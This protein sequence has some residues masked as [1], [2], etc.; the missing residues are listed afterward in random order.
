M[1]AGGEAEFDGKAS[2]FRTCSRKVQMNVQRATGPRGRA[3]MCAGLL[4]AAWGMPLVALADDHAPLTAEDQQAISKR[5]LGRMLMEGRPNK[6]A[7]C[8]V[9]NP[10]PEQMAAI[11][12]QYQALPPTVARDRF[13]ISGTSWTGNGGQGT[14]GRS[15]AAQLTYSFPPDGTT[16]GDPNGTTGP[17]NLNAL[18]D[19]VFGAGNRDQGRELLRQ[20][21]A[22]WRK[23]TGLSY[24]EVADDGSTMDFNVSRLGTR[25]DVRIGAINDATLASQGVLAYNFFPDGGSDMTIITQQFSGSLA[26]NANSYRY[27]RNTVAHEHG[28]GLGYQHVVPCSNTKLMEPFLSTAFDQTQIDDRRGGMYNY[29]DRF[30]GNVDAANARDFGNLTST[31][32]RS[33]IERNLSTNRR[34]GNTNT[35]NDWFRFTI[36][37]V[38][39]VVITAAPTGGTYTQ[40]TQS[41][42]CAGTTT[43][44]NTTAAGN[45][46]IELRNNSGAT[47]LQT[48]AASGAGLNEVL[49]ANGL[50]AGTYWVRVFDANATGTDQNSV[51]QMYDLTIRVGTSTAAPYAVAGVNKRIQANANCFFMGNINSEATETGATITAYA[52]DLDGNGTFEN[53]FAQ[54]TTTY[55]SNGLYNV[56]LR[57]TDSNGNTDTDTIQVT[58]FGAITTITS[59]SPS[60]SAANATVPVTINGTN[61]RGVTTAAQFTASGTGVT[62]SG[63]PVVNPLGTQVTGLSLVIASNAPLGA[64]DITVVNSDGQGGTVTAPAAF[65][66]TGALP[67]NDECTGALAWPGGA[68][69]KA[70]MNNFATNSSPQ[71]FTGTGCTGNINNDVWYTWTAAASNVV[72]VTTDSAGAGFSSRVA[73]Y[74]NTCPIGAPIECGEFGQPYQFNAVAGTTYLFRVGSAVPNITGTANVILS[75]AAPSGACCRP[76]ATCFVATANLCTGANVYQGNFTSCVPVPCPE[77]IGACCAANGTCT[78]VTGAACD[79]SGGTW[80]DVGSSCSPNPCQQPTGA[81]CATNGT[82]SVTAQAGCTA[83]FSG[84]GTTCV[85]NNCPQPTGACCATNGTCSIATQAACSASFSGAGTVCVPNTCPQPT[86]ACCATNGTCSVTTQAGCTA[87]FSGAGTVCVPNTC[88]QPTGACCA[89]DG[90]CSVTTQAGCAA[91]FSGA[92]TVCV[93]NTC[94][95]PTGACC[96][97][98][99]SCSVTTQAACTGSWS[100]PSTSCV[101]NNCQQ[102]TGAC[103]AGTTCSISTAATCVGAN[104]SFSGVGTVCNASGN[105]TTPCCK[106]NFHQITGVSVQDIFGFL[107]AWF[108]GDPLADF[109]GAGGV[110]VQ[111]IFDFLAAWFAGC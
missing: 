9:P 101:P 102:P 15:L 61:F 58:V 109:N 47:V 83:S 91:S 62:F 57:V 93:P 31:A 110:S 89:T 21:F 27:F 28:H 65:T 86:G 88:P 33:I 92:G 105:N 25:G 67:V 94:P 97:A 84:L 71:S 90:T 38:Q 45:L 41:N 3:W 19:G 75:L 10:T 36:G 52:W 53:N 73:V 44:T 54:P 99:G 82:C 14:G 107:A 87:S 98:S 95:Q 72:T 13:F 4:A 66:I 23:Y 42:G 104:R 48:A 22:S 85:P 12:Q 39:N 77:P 70:F 2:S 100:G 74:P 51:L 79:T 30:A 55:P 43:S 29:G 49:T 11:M 96:A 64:R 103:C 63:T 40:G 17:N 81:C 6:P 20:A 8:F 68:G 111:D 24:T 78:F 108:A 34:T 56:Q 26:G 37:N 69:S 60:S 35:N 32:V 106:A 46:N 16:W 59:L 1:F 18:F 7:Y 76:D 50:A 80:L 5:L